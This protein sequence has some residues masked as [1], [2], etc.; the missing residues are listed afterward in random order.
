VYDGFLRREPDGKITMIDTDYG[1]RATVLAECDT[2]IVIKW[3][4]HSA[5]RGVLLGPEWI[6]P[7]VCVCAKEMRPEKGLNGEE[8]PPKEYLR[9]VIEWDAGRMKKEK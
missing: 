3:P 1:G 6:S 9:V 7:K 2:F 8:I 5:Y 4:G